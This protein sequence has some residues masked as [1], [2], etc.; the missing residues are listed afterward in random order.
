M[1]LNASQLDDF[2]RDGY[3]LL[4]ELFDAEQMR[5][6]LAEMEKIF[7]GKSFADYL[8]GIDA[9]ATAQ[10]VEPVKTAA[11]PHYGNT[12]HGRAQF[13]T[14]ADA[15][16]RLIE[17]DDYLDIFEQ[18]LG[19][20]ASY[21]NAHLFLRSGPTDERFSECPWQ[22]YHIDHYS[23][24]FLPPSPGVGTFDYVNSGIYLHDVDE[25]G[26]P[27]HLIPGSHRQVAK[28]FPRLAA[29]D[30]LISGGSISDIRDVTELAQPQP[31][32]AKAGSV[33]LYS[34]W[35]VHAAVPFQNRRKQRA[36]WTLSMARTD[37]S[38]WTKLSNPWIGTERG[39]IKPFWEQTTPRV[40]SLFGWPKPGHAYYDEAA[41]A[42]LRVLYPEMDLSPYR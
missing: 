8:A 26:A 34:S 7:Y 33:L 13:A 3:I 40:R 37:A 2:Q 22:G 5:A 6:G 32:I 31:A 14:G 21:C 30:D 11:V 25:D 15:L 27:M 18:C 17:S 36:L 35:V 9:G 12:K 29:E 41:L 4:P 10:S 20:E 16:D 28:L 19:G 24:C 23:N 39:F 38:R 42:N 1:P